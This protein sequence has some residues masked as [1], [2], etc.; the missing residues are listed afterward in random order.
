MLRTEESEK[1]FG[2]NE[3]QYSV[4]DNVCFIFG[5]DHFVRE[6]T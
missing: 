4:F 6:F 2:G 5:I 1:L 3:L